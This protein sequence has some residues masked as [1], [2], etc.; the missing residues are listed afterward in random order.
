MTSSYSPASVLPVRHVTYLCVSCDGRS[1]VSSSVKV[2]TGFCAD[3]ATAVFPL[4]HYR[5]PSSHVY[6]FFYLIALN[7][8]RALTSRED[9][10][11]RKS[12]SN[13]ELITGRPGRARLGQQTLTG[14]LLQRMTIFLEISF[15]SQLYI[16][17]NSRSSSTS[18]APF[19]SILFLFSFSKKNRLLLSSSGLLHLPYWIEIIVASAIMYV[20]ITVRYHYFIS[21]LQRDLGSYELW[22]T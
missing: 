9:K 16:D 17:P 2:F 10:V 13:E 20:V 19:I 8:S 21:I 6:G 12:L 3:A 11:T 7:N 4:K 14:N 1:L 15:I 5:N 22:S 18:S